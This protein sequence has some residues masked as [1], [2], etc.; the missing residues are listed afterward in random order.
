M[1]RRSTGVEI[2]CG[3]YLSGPM[4][5]YVDNNIPRFA[6][7]ASRLRGRGYRV[8]NPGEWGAGPWWYCVS[9]D[10]TFMF[11]LWVTRRLHMIVTHGTW[12]LSRGAVLEVRLAS[13]LGLTRWAITDFFKEEV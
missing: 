8:Y 12:G 10:L 7:L 1:S 2:N 5:G 11:V 4:T 9:R 13:K 6:E 3:I